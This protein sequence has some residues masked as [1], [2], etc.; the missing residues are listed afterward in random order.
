MTDECNYPNTGLFEG[1]FFWGEGQFD[2]LHISGRTN[3]DLIQLC[4]IVK[5]PI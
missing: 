2:P 1:S 3:L 4:K 5:Q